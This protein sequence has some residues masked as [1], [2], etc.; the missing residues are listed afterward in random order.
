MTIWQGIILGLVQGVSEF[1]PISS[2]GHLVIFQKLLGFT[3]PPI[4]FDILVHGATLISVLL[5]FHRQ[6]FSLTKKE[7]LLLVVGSIPA[8]IAGIF[9][10]PYLEFMFDSNALLIGGFIVTGI[11]MIKTTHFKD[12][13]EANTPYKAM[14]IGIYQ[15]VA[16]FP[17]ISRSGSTVFGA[18]QV[19]LSTK[20]AFIFSFLL[21]IPAILGAVVLHL[22]KTPHL[23]IGPGEAAGFLIALISSLLSIAVLNKL[24]INKKLHYFGYYCLALSFVLIFFYY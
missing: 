14:L 24:M 1:L 6:I 13:D 9:L 11:L 23:S 22:I 5:Y 12:R 2:S 7:F 15:A 17:S 18:L 20:N 19:G 16:I 21:S 10:E 4:S 3:T 8:G